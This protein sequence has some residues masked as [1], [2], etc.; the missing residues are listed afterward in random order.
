MRAST[1]MSKESDTA[2]S[3][4]G[5]KMRTNP[6][7]QSAFHSVTLNKSEFTRNRLQTH[8]CQNSSQTSHEET[9]GYEQEQESSLWGRKMDI[10]ETLWRGTLKV[11]TAVIL[12]LCL[13]SRWL[14]TASAERGR[15]GLICICL[16][17][18]IS[19]ILVTALL[20]TMHMKPVSVQRAKLWWISQSQCD[21]TWLCSCSCCVSRHP[22]LVFIVCGHPRRSWPVSLLTYSIWKISC[23]NRRCPYVHAVLKNFISETH[24]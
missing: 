19:Q 5:T 23:E 18:Y 1:W 13:D 12:T 15:A 21:L 2:F 22:L 8:E 14:T 17:P 6:H 7:H 16:H 10:V 24:R 3:V 11:T 4:T 20:Q 9:A